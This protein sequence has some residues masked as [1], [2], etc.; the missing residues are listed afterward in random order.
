MLDLLPIFIILFHFCYHVYMYGFVFF[1][2]STISILLSL[3]LYNYILVLR[4]SLRFSLSSLNKK[5]IKNFLNL[6]GI[7]D[8]CP[9]IL[10]LASMLVSATL[11]DGQLVFITFQVA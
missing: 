1:N 8:F 4:V 10:K 11:I 6:F 9:V 2:E 7:L 5:H 3:S